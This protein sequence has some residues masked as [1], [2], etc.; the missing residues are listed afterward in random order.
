MV[1]YILYSQTV[2]E[3]DAIKHKN[4]KRILNVQQLRFDSLMSMQKATPNKKKHEE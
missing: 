3:K 4:T 2:K 1:N